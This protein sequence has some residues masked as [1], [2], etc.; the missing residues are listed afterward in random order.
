MEPGLISLFEWEAGLAR[1]VDKTKTRKALRKLRKVAERAQ[2]EDA[3]ELSEWEKEFVDGVATRLE[4]YGSA[5]R[6]PTKGSLEEALSQ[7]Q[8]QVVRVLDKKTRPKTKQADKPRKPLKAKSGFKRK[9]PERKGRVR[10]I[11]EDVEAS[12]VPQAEPASPPDIPQDPAAR[13]AAMRVIRG[14]RS[15]E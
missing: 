4:T 13:R 5:F 14:G 8:T 1:E 15:D 12:P 7:R 11:N 9:T 10:D 6:D 2:A 3:P